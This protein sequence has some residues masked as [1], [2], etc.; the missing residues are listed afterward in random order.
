MDV[1]HPDSGR[2]VAGERG[3]AL[4]IA[5]G[6]MA[7]L[8]M[9]LVGIVEFSSAGQRNASR[10][11][12]SQSAYWFAEAGVNNA[13]SVISTYLDDTSKM[14][15]QPAYAGDPNSTTTP[16]TGGSATWG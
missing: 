14:R 8:S 10:G 2:R 7:V 5:L 9:I 1:R 3:S 4:V 11:G 12:A 15:P 6:C 13:V 16:Y